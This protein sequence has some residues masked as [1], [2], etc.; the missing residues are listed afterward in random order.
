MVLAWP[1]FPVLLATTFFTFLFGQ[2]PKYGFGRET[3]RQ[4]RYRRKNTGQFDVSATRIQWKTSRTEIR[5]KVLNERVRTLFCL[6]EQ[7]WEIWFKT[8]N[9]NQAYGM[10]CINTSCMLHVFTIAHRLFGDC[11][12]R[13]CLFPEGRSKELPKMGCGGRGGGGGGRRLGI[14]V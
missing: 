4:G 11:V 2:V 12:F 5:P 10:A 3:D 13:K 9:I 14:R 1:C 7:F 8:C 6:P